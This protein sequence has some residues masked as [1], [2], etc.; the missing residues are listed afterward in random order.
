VRVAAVDVGTNTV[1][2]LIA[3]RR[4]GELV[5]LVEEMA[6]CRLGKGVDRTGRLDD[7]AI[8]RTLVA[9]RG[10]GETGRAHGVDRAVAVGTQALREAQ[11]GED[12]LLRAR[13][14]LGFPV[15]VISGGREARLAWRAVSESFP[16]T[17]RRTVID[18]GGGSTEILIGATEIEWVASVPIG[19]VRLTERYVAHDPPTDHE[20]LDVMLAIDRSLYGAPQLEGEIIGVA[21]T[22]TT[23]AAMHLGL[24][25]YDGG[26]VHGARLGR[27]ALGQLVVRLGDASFE[28]RR[29]MRGL[30]PRRADVIWAGAMILARIVERA[31]AAGVLVSDR[32]V[33]WGLAHELAG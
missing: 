10:F 16:A 6:I 15:E 33:R 4:G 13:E 30:D 24:D 5:P 21:G 14:A 32:G 9:L 7:A 27:D 2:L 23:L 28:Q 12:F 17:G 1:L 20:I 19:S 31:G 25:S 3:E 18:I 22:V 8:E 11:N 29:R 26:L